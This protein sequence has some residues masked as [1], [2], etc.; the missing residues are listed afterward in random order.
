MGIVTKRRLFGASVT[1]ALLATTRHAWS[2][3]FPVRPIRLI[4]PV[5]PGGSLDI[6]ARTLSKELTPRLGQ[7]VLVENHAGAGGNIAFGLAAQSAADG[8][9]VLHGWDSLVINPALYGSVPYRLNQFAPVTLAVTSPQVLVTNPARQPAVDFAEFASLARQ[10]PRQLT[11]ASAG[12]G[13]PGHLAL[14]LLERQA[15]LELVHVPYKGGGPAVADL[16][17][18]H[19]DALFV[20]LP[21]ALP[22][23]RSGKLRALGVSSV[24]RSAGAPQIPTLAESGVRGVELESWQGFLVPQGTPGDAIGRL[25]REIVAV[26]Q[27]PEVRAN[28]VN[29]GFEVVAG[30]PDAMAGELAVGGPRWGALVKASGA[31]VD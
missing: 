19:V 8:Y 17:A 13:S 2:Q 28:L 16:L 9:V 10:R 25:N 27:L 26:L 21:P 31:R 4:L 22:H 20:T 12:A 29:Q 14:S 30:G 3:S 5:A 15:G 18:G 1:A 6:L 7:P 23:I 24:R 11:V